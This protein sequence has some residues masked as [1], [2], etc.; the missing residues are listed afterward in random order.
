[1]CVSCGCGQ[2]NDDH[3]NDDNL[4]MTDIIKAMQ[5]GG[6][7]SLEEV[8]DN[9]H[10]ATNVAQAHEDPVEDDDEDNDEQDEFQEAHE[11][12]YK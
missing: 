5:A 10:F 11:N 4:V 3:G 6:V 9:V 12:Y 1:M 8:G 2:F 7:G